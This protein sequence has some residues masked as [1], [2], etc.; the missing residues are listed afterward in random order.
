MANQIAPSSP[1]PPAYKP[2][3]HVA[4]ALAVE[5]CRDPRSVFA[6]YEGRAQP[7]TT[8]S[9][10]RAAVKLGVTPPPPKGR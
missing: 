4:R 1:P 2:D 8:E 7:V 6:A 5:S 3:A 10:R 9:V